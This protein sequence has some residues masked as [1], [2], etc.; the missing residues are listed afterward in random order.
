M[1][2]RWTLTALLTVAVAA[3]AQPAEPPV[4]AA[5]AAQADTEAAPS[6]AVQVTPGPSP[7][8]SSASQPQV[9]VGPPPAAGG[10][11]AECPE[12]AAVPPGQFLMGSAPDAP[13]VD[14]ATG[15]TP[16]LPV[17]IARPFLIGKREVTVG[18]FRRFVAATGYGVVDECSIWQG[19]QWV[20]ERGRS[21]QDPGYAQP[22]RDD[23]PV[24]CVN[25]D[26]AQAYADWLA[27]RSG[28]RYRL[29]SEAEWEYVARG[30]TSLAR[31][32]GG[33]DSNEQAP[34]SLAC[35]F[36]NVYDM[37]AVASN[38]LPWP[39]ARCED[40]HPWLASVGEYK[41]NAFGVFDIIGNAREWVADC[42]TASYRGRP[43]DARAWTWTGGCE[44]RGVRGGSWA[45]RPAAARAAAR[46]AEL[47]GLR[48]SDLG[49]RVARDF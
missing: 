7:A 42:Y 21:W 18:E 23:E 5:A 8:A 20:H 47:R 34:V 43:Q 15:E 45:S 44:Q 22:P 9:T 36:A 3:A 25:W 2:S 6:A 48:Q 27:Q 35:E 40:R 39:N 11:C 32:W 4:A 28:K 37:T 41:P 19:G 26:D 16:A 24:V 17:V 31:F 33:G 14:A 38:P 1:R 13:E 10:D 49:F 12:L 30:G 46:G 29:P